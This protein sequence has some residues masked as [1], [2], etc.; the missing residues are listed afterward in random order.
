MSKMD[1]GIDIILLSLLK[2]INVDV[3]D[4]LGSPL[5]HAVASGKHDIVRV[6]LYH[7][8][9]RLDDAADAF[10][11]GLKLDPENKELQDAFRLGTI[12]FIT[13]CAVSFITSSITA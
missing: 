7:G 12:R 2:G 9:N 1:Q 13:S 5:Q 6:L 3:M 8:A 10:F 4:E 11:D